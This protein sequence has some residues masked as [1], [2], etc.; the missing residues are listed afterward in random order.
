MNA[1]T[2]LVHSGISTHYVSLPHLVIVRLNEIARN[3]TRYKERQSLETIPSFLLF[4]LT[5]FLYLW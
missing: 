4:S 2:N 3:S 1:G 5:R